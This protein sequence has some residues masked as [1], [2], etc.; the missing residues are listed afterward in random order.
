MTH[1]RTIKREAFDQVTNEF[2]VFSS[3]T[4]KTMFRGRVKGRVLR[5]AILRA[6]RLGEKSDAH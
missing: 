1:N 5:R 2:Q 3:V 6:I 4:G